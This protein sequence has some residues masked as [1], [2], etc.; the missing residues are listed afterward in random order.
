MKAIRKYNNLTIEVEASDQ[1]SLF[2]QLAAM[3]DVFG[4]LQAAAIIDGELVTSDDVSFVVRTDKD[5]NDYFEIR[6]NSGPLEWYKK[7]LGQ[8]KRGKTLFARTKA[9]D[10]E[11][12]GLRGW[13]KYDPN[14]IPSGDEGF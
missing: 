5:E 9:P 10:N 3:D 8:H 13:S 4:D 14:Y 1:V 7:R 2:K 12:Q 11:I 6:C